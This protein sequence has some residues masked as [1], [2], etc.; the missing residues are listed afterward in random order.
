[1][2]PKQVAGCNATQTRQMV[3]NQRAFFFPFGVPLYYSGL[4]QICRG[5]Y[6]VGNGGN[7]ST[8]GGLL[9]TTLEIPWGRPGRLY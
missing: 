1:M 2:Y 9:K 6:P 3:Q 5:V 7:T 8:L 4:L